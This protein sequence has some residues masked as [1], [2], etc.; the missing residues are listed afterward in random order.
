ML[1]NL[2][3]AYGRGENLAIDSDGTTQRFQTRAV[4]P[5]DLLHHPQGLEAVVRSEQDL[6][7]PWIFRA[8]HITWIVSGEVDAR[9]AARAVELAESKYCAV[10]ATIKDVVRLSHS[11][12]LLGPEDV[13]RDDPAS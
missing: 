1:A 4:A 10:A 9:K 2:R 6:D 11:I 3:C 8:I 13:A 7:P 5:A 12:E